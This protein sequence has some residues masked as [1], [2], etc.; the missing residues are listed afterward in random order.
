MSDFERRPTTKETTESRRS[1]RRHSARIRDLETTLS[2]LQPMPEQ[3]P[4][5]PELQQRYEAATQEEGG[6]G[7]GEGDSPPS[8]SAFPQPPSPSL[9]VASAMR[10][11]GYTTPRRDNASTRATLA[12]RHSSSN[13]LLD[14][15]PQPRPPYMARTGG[16]Q[17]SRG[18]LQSAAAAGAAA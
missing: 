18:S 14:T 16:S 8:P 6:E 5:Q 13:S 3:H 7:G 11:L 1:S 12:H 9:S 2:Q 4:S 17:D 10:A 15:P